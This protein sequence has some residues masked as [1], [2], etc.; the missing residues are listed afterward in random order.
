[1]FKK[2]DHDGS[3]KLSKAEYDAL[4]EAG[5]EGAADSHD[6]NALVA[7][8]DKDGDKKL[9]LDEFLAHSVGANSPGDDMTADDK[10]AMAKLN[11]ETRAR[12]PH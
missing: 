10:S 1:M 3:G 7:E 12:R 6:G 11:A 9:S 4:D 5:P 2:F 8:A